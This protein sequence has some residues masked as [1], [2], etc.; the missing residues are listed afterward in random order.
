MSAEQHEWQGNSDAIKPQPGEKTARN[1]QVRFAGFSHRLS[2]K[3]WIRKKPSIRINS[4]NDIGVLVLPGPGESGG[5]GGLD[6]CI[7]SLEL[8]ES[9]HSAALSVFTRHPG[10]ELRVGFCLSPGEDYTRRRRSLS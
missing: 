1:Q 3:L 5:L 7:S 2:G 4:L 9:N 8:L 6:H 10:Y